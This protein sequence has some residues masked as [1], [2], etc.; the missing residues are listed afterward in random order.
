MTVVEPGM[1]HATARVLVAGVIAECRVFLEGGPVRT[2]N[3][4]T[5]NLNIVEEGEK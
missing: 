2:T 5:E 1:I 4:Y 3:V